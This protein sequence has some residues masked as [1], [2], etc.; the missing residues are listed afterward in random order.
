M[1]ATSF[2]QDVRGGP[3]PADDGAFKLVE[4]LFRDSINPRHEIQPGNRQQRSRF[5]ELRLGD[6]VDTNADGCGNILKHTQLRTYPLHKTPRGRQS[7]AP[8]GVMRH[9]RSV[10]IRLLSKFMGIIRTLT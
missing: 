6:L 1:S 10:S 8:C 3:T 7:P 2:R 5:M 9:P 4:L